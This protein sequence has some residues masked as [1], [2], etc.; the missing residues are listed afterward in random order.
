MHN[1]ATYRAAPV[2]EAAGISNVSAR[3]FAAGKV[4]VIA[5]V[6]RER[7]ES[8]AMRFKKEAAVILI[9]SILGGD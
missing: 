4:T 1:G 9:R 2:I 8:W 3:R 6:F 5:I 7:V